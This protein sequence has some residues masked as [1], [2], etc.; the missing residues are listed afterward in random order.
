MQASLNSVTSLWAVHPVPP[1][2]LGGAQTLV[3]A[4]GS[5]SRYQ[6]WACSLLS[7]PS[8]SAGELDCGLQT[9]MAELTAGSSTLQCKRQMR[10]LQLLDLL[11]GSG[12]APGFLQHDHPQVHVQAGKTSR[13]ERH[14]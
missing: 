13:L 12:L 14:S 9:R 10:H 1:I 11:H 2:V 7:V 5:E 4:S 8:V 3:H 6:L